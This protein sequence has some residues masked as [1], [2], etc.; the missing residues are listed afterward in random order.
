MAGAGDGRM[1]IDETKMLAAISEG[2]RR[3]IANE[4]SDARITAI[5]PDKTVVDA[6]REGVFQA[7]RSA[8]EDKLIQMERP[9]D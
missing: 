7:F 2:V 3:A 9:E 8:I 5:E 4:F 6:I 1:N